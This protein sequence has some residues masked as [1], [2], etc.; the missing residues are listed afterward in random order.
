[1]HPGDQRLVSHA[2]VTLC[3]KLM[4]F[5][6]AWVRVR[7]PNAYSCSGILGK[8]PPPSAG[9]K[10]TPTLRVQEF[11]SAVHVPPPTSTRLHNRNPEAEP[12][13]PRPPF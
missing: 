7:G 2:A 3:I 5:A 4:L 11:P 9:T 6:G 13:P 8:S 10:C 1:M 12:P